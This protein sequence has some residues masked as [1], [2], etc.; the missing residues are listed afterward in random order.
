MNSKTTNKR[1]MITLFAKKSAD[2]G[3]GSMIKQQQDRSIKKPMTGVSI[4][5]DKK[6]SATKSTSSNRKNRSTSKG[7]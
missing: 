6:K 2:F 7:S 4:I 5:D 3:S 1:E